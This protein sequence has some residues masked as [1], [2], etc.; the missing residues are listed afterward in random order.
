[1][2]IVSI[3]IVLVITAVVVS[4]AGEQTG[5]IDVVQDAAQQLGVAAIQSGDSLVDG[6]GCGGVLA[7]DQQAGIGILCHALDRKSVV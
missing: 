6:R 1:M 2:A 5:G 4:L 3:V 7:D